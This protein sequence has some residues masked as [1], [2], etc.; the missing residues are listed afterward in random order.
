VLET[1]I[2][3]NKYLIVFAKELFGFPIYYLMESE[4]PGYA[5]MVFYHPEIQSELKKKKEQY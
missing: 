1:V 5:A 2:R 3:D 4:V